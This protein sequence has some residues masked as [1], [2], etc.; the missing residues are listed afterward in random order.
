M[1]GKPIKSSHE[2]KPEPPPVAPTESIRELKE[3]L[4]MIDKRTEYFEQR[5]AAEL[6]KAKAETVRKNKKGAMQ[7]LSRKQN[8]DAEVEKLGKVRFGM[9]Q[10]M[11]AIEGVH[12][13]AGMFKAMKNGRSA[14][15]GLQTQM[16]PDEV[17]DQ[18]DEISNQLGTADEVVRALS[19]PLGNDVQDEFE[20]EDAFNALEQEALDEQ[21][22]EMESKKRP[23]EKPASRVPEMPSVPATKVPPPDDDDE[24][25]LRRLEADMAL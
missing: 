12:F 8:Y 17:G 1:F 14:M 2:P 5:A 19:Q 25:A 7:C 6:A 18:M 23:S 21:L 10:Q 9:E 16:D 15:R 20:L 13:S 4:A 11:L 24:E 3:A 22:L